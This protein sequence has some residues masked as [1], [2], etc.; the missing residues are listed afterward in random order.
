MSVGTRPADSGEVSS[1]WGLRL[2]HAFVHA[3]TA[4]VFVWPLALPEAAIAAAGGSFVAALLAPTLARSRLRAPALIGVALAVF[5][6]ALLTRF[7]VTGVE[8]VTLALGAESALRAGDGLFFFFAAGAA[9]LALR[10]ATLRLRAFGAL[11][12]G[13]IAWS[14]G[15]LVVAHRQGAI[16]RPF[17]LADPIMSTGGDPTTVFFFVGGCAT[18]VVVLLLLRESGLRSLL[19]LA[20]V[21]LL[22]LVFFAS[23]SALEMPAPPPGGAGLGLRPEEGEGD[24]EDGEGGEGG[25]GGEQRNDDELEF[26]DNIENDSDQAPVGV[27]LFHDDYSAPTGT[28]YFRQGAFS[29]FN[30]NRLVAAAG[31]GLN[32][33][34]A[35]DFPLRA[36]DVEGAPPLNANRTQVRTTV[37]L[38]AEHTRPFGLEAPITLQPATNPDPERFRRTYSVTSAV[39]LADFVSMVGSV[40]GNPAWTPET[41]QHYTEGPDDPRYA[42]LAQ[43]IIQE[44][45]PPHLMEDPVARVAA[46]T[47]WLGREGTYSLRTRHADADDPT[48]NFLFGDKTGYCV[49]FAHAGAYLLRASGI[50]TRVATGYAIAEENRRGG[51]ALLVSGNTSHAWPEVYLDGFGWVVTDISPQ[52]V[53]SPPP[54]PPDA[55]LQRL[56]GE[57]ARGLRPLPPDPEAP[58]PAAIAQGIDV[59]RALGWGSLVF[60][61]LVFIVLTVLKFWRRLSP[62]FA[63]DADQARVAYRAA[64]DRLSE[65]GI[66]R[67]VGESRE[68]FAARVAEELPSLDS[69]TRHNVAAAFGSR[70]RFTKSEA[71]PLLRTL[72]KELSAHVPLWRRL[73]GV[74]TPW[75]W[76]TSR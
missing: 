31:A 64:L 18:A 67:E 33:D 36:Y 15:Q 37:A 41:R 39:M 54:A 13:A 52:N 68:S 75:S 21:S 45:L 4:T 35:Q 5:G 61:V 73:L 60:G 22:L 25:E 16:N 11:E 1:G 49:H 59:L 44:S 48:A 62:S 74:L 23:S 17:E 70:R 24:P 69:L 72:Q 32:N 38:L 50:P 76:I 9:T 27:V 8:S 53:I 10:S 58:L 40:A 42:E 6:V 7:A 66:R 71:L 30:G 14:F 65:N 57:L 43:R 3:L 55:D 46:I 47:S 12:V 19:H 34:I 29:Q 2:L 51:S 28:Y 63:A 26:R 20:A 56:L